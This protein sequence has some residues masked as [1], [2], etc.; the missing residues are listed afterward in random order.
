MRAGKSD[1][2][3]GYVSCYLITLK[4]QV[5]LAPTL[6]GGVKKPAAIFGR[7]PKIVSIWD[8]S[9]HFLLPNGIF[10]GALKG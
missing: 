10:C 7:A 4:N 5:F 3:L 6:E 8:Y 2:G 9:T 1:Y